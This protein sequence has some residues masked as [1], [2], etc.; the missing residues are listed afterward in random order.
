MKNILIIRSANMAAM[1]KLINYIKKHNEDYNIYCLIQKGSIKNFKEKYPCINY[2]EKEDGFFKY[3]DFKKNLD[4]KNKLKDI[5][6]DS[7]YI[8]SSYVDFP[9]FQD[10]FMIASKIASRKYILFNIEEEIQ[11]QNLNFMLLW[12]DKYLGEIIYFIKVLFALI[13]I[14]II[15]V[16]GYP[17]YF[18]KNKVMRDM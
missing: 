17:Y 8:P 4:L 14:F 7:I 16:L 15:Y 13:G 2:I 18:L 5:N 9:D 10:T 12:I 1:D 3:K 6:L 11:E